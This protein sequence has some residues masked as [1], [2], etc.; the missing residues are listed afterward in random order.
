LGSAIFGPPASYDNHR[1]EHGLELF[2]QFLKKLHR[3]SF[4]HE[5]E[6]GL[7]CPATFALSEDGCLDPKK[8][9]Y[10]NGIWLEIGAGGVAHQDMARMFPNLRIVALNGFGST[11]A[12]G[13]SSAA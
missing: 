10:A 1:R 13:S 6:M 9:A 12:R 7:F 8:V 11:K 5:E 2:I 3:S 4:E